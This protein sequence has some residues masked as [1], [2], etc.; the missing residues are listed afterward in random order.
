M[1][2]FRKIKEALPGIMWLLILSLVLLAILNIGHLIWYIVKPEGFWD[3]LYFLRTCILTV[4]GLFILCYIAYFIFIGV[5]SLLWK[6]TFKKLLVSIGCIVLIILI[7]CLNLF[8]ISYPELNLYARMANKYKYLEKS[9]KL[10]NSAQFEDALRYAKKAKSHLRNGDAPW[11]VFLLTWYYRTTEF[12]K[13]RELDEQFAVSINYGYCLNKFDSLKLQ[14][15]QE[16]NNALS[17]TQT[18]LL[19]KRKDYKIFPLATLIDIY[20]ENS[21]FDKVDSC[22]IELL[23]YIQYAEKKDIQYFIECQDQIAMYTL[24]TGDETAFA[25]LC[26][27]NLNSYKKAGLSKKSSEYL[28][29]LT[30]AAMG[31]IVLNDIKTAGELL[32]EAQPLA[33]KKSKGEVYINYLLVKA[34]YC[35]IASTMDAG[36]NKLIKKGVLASLFAMFSSPVPERAQFKALAQKCYKMLVERT[37]E[38]YG[39][40]SVDF[41]NSRFHLANFYLRSRDYTEAQKVYEQILTD[42]KEG[43]QLPLNLR[44]RVYVASLLCSLMQ[45]KEQSD[46]NEIGRIEESIFED[47]I[48]RLLYMNEYERDKYANQVQQ[49]IEIV[50]T[51]LIK[52]NTPEA[53]IHLYNNILESKNLVL[54]TNRYQR[55]LIKDSVYGLKEK[56][57]H[58]LEE[59]DNQYNGTNVFLREKSFLQSVRSLPGF[60]FYHPQNVT[61]LDVR[62]SLSKGD[63]AVEY[64]TT[65]NSSADSAVNEYYALILQS[66]FAYPKL[67]RICGEKE[68]NNLVNN[69]DNLISQINATYVHSLSN[70]RNILVRPIFE[71]IKAPR[72]L[73]I[74]P[75]GKIHQI[76]IPA[77]FEDISVNYD[78]VGSTR[79]LTEERHIA[80]QRNSAIL[81]GDID[82][83]PIKEEKN[84]KSFERLPFTLQEVNKIEDILLS[85]KISPEIISGSNATEK[86]FKS[87]SG[88]RIPVIHIATHGYYDEQSIP[89]E[90]IE[91]NTIEIF[92]SNTSMLKCNLLF[93]GSNQ[94]Q[95]FGIDKSKD[96]IVTA[97]DIS[98]MDLT[99][100]ELVVL[101]ACE[102]GLGQINGLEGVQGFQRAFSLAGANMVLVTLWKISDK[103][104]AEIMAYFYKSLAQGNTPQR[105]LKVA[106][107]KMKEL[108]DNP[109]YWAGFV[110][111]SG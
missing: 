110:I 29:R 45:G 5:A 30:V 27:S 63:V 50:N 57:L 90:D 66:D 87:L 6:F 99:G 56:Y 92:Q 88:S 54:Y 103:Y 55:N 16:Y 36:N 105:A 35:V 23:S 58:L 67:V 95:E 44:N 69:R 19:S 89:K 46:L 32:V 64:F 75:S 60:D 20:L 47:A 101:S 94:A 77:L 17:L 107:T 3:I 12:A 76:S 93:A 73:F 7:Q 37:G 43:K 49:S 33:E 48:N 42:L 70:L 78:I 81:I 111:I 79:F 98:R 74:S 2:L 8:Q 31:S 106:Q 9:E 102:T 26:I 86:A 21:E 22:N 13:L 108:Y 18:S 59:K 62:R 91:T 84:R 14:S 82:Y 53:N 4:G 85:S 38:R 1:T 51:I 100:T 24:R 65:Y 28:Y 15:I 52:I 109:Y 34:K 39:N 41:E 25:K 10:V 104:T 11:P 80:P 97:Q 83:G 40:N 61:W 71:N 72:H 68:L 96:G